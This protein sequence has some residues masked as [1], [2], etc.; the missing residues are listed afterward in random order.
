[1]LRV[2]LGLPGPTVGER[3]RRAERA[4]DEFSAK[5][6]HIGLSE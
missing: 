5:L 1:M 2:L 4:R 3:R 6:R